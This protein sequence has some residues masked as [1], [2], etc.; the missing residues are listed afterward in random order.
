MTENERQFEERVFLRNPD[1]KEI[2]CV[3]QARDLGKDNKPATGETH[4]SATEQHILRH[5]EQPIAK[6]S[7]QVR[8]AAYEI[9][10]A[11]RQGPDPAQIDDLRSL[12][13]EV[14]SVAQEI[15]LDSR[16]QLRDDRRGQSRMVRDLNWFKRSNG[17]VREASYPDSAVF[18]YALV[19]VVIVAESAL[20]MYFF[21]QGSTYGLLGGFF[22]ALLISITNVFLALL[23]GT[24]A[25]RHLNHKRSD[26]RILGL[27]SFLVYLPFAS[28]FNLVAGHY[29]DLLERHS[30]DFANAAEVAKVL[31]DAIPSALGDPMNVTFNSLMLITLG[32]I[33]SSFGLF[34]G[35]TSDDRYPG[36]GAVH[37]RFTEASNRF[38]ETQKSVR[39]KLVANLRQVRENSSKQLKDARDP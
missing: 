3:Q 31:G 17:L 2:D 21:A 33:A 39:N 26:L 11:T 7:D 9:L 24:W 5:F 22:Q 35:F 29:R 37:R 20:N 30:Q 36:Y 1:G 27:L 12:A 32:M 18:H 19:S 28:F 38:S 16:D 6:L 13:D 10:V 34:K 14:R 25:L 23:A 4:I 8:G 15:R